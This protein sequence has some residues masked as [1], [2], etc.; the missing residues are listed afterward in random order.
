[1]V[2]PVNARRR[3]QPAYAQ[4]LS[5]LK[6]DEFFESESGLQEYGIVVKDNL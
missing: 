4:D 6:Y 3:I 5:F 2:W 1:M